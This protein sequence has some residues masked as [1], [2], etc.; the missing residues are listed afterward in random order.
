MV[1]YS[2]SESAG[3]IAKME[4]LLRRVRHPELRMCW[5]QHTVAKGRFAI[6]HLPGES[7]PADSLSKSSDRKHAQLFVDVLA[8]SVGDRGH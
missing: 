5:I 4:G 3:N 7:N 8:G 1:I 2:D 6:R